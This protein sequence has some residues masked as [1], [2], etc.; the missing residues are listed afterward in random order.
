MASTQIPGRWVIR[1]E[2]AAGGTQE[3]ATLSINQTAPGG[4][5][6]DA[7]ATKVPT[8]NELLKISGTGVTLQKDDILLMSYIPQAAATIDIS[9]SIWSIPLATSN[10]S[11]DLLIG[12]FDEPTPADATIP[13]GVETVIGGYRVV[14][15]AGVSIAGNIFADLQDNTA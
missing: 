5:A 9:D 12:D 3:I 1:R 8:P 14:D 2:L 4:G 13:A 11:K 15:P 7:D 6:P 10:G